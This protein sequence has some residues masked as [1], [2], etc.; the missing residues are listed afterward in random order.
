MTGMSAALI[1]RDPTIPEVLRG[2]VPLKRLGRAAEIASV[3]CFL[4]SPAASF[5]HGAIIP[6]DGGV[7]ANVG[8]Y[9]PPDP[10]AR[11]NGASIGARHA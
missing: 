3:I 2:N 9:P 5:V 8:Q 7:T 1:E 11:I 6:V 4:A 10:P